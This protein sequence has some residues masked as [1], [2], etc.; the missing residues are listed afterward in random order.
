LFQKAHSA[1]KGTGRVPRYSVV[2]DENSY[3]MDVLEGFT[4]ALS[5]EHQI[6]ARATS[7]PTPV[8][9]AEGYAQRGRDVFNAE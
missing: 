4:H 8:Y 2:L 5:Y 7:L 3:T 9:V 6:V 1:L